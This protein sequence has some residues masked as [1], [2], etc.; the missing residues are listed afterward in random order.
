MATAMDVVRKRL[1]YE[2]DQKWTIDD[3]TIALSLPNRDE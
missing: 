3:V 1:E 2:D